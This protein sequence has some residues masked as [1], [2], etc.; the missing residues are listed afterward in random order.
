MDYQ[1]V[2]CVWAIAWNR[3]TGGVEACDFFSI[4]FSLYVNYIDVAIAI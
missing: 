2:S 3:G 1:V 4:S